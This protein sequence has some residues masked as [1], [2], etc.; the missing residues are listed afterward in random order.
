MTFKDIKKLKRKTR[1]FFKRLVSEEIWGPRKRKIEQKMEDYS[2]FILN[3]L[4]KN[5]NK[6]LPFAVDVP[7]TQEASEFVEFYQGRTWATSYEEEERQ[8]DRWVNLIDDLIIQLEEYFQ[9]EIE[10][11]QIM[12]FYPYKTSERETYFA[13]RGSQ[14]PKR[15]EEEFGMLTLLSE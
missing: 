7:L 10:N 2:L 9:E 15:L 8:R 3:I 5:K 6:D 13:S 12:Q 11:T 4:W 14:P 1:R